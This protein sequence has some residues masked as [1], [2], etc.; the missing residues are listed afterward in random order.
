[1]IGNELTVINHLEKEC[2]AKTAFL[3]AAEYGIIRTVRTYL[4]DSP[5]IIHTVS[6]QRST[7]LHLAA[8]P[9]A[10]ALPNQ[11]LVE[12]LLEAGADVLARDYLGRTPLHYAIQMPSHLGVILRSIGSKTWPNSSDLILD[13]ALQAI[14]T[15][16]KDHIQSADNWNKTSFLHA[17]QSN[18]WPL[19]KAFV[20]GGFNADDLFD[21]HKLFGKNNSYPP[22][23]ALQIAILEGAKWS[24]DAS[25]RMVR[26]LLDAGVDP[27]MKGGHGETALHHAVWIGSTIIA[28]VL[29]TAGAD[30]NMPNNRG[31]API[32]WVTKLPVLDLLL[33]WGVDVNIQ[34]NR[35]MTALHLTLSSLYPQALL[36]PSLLKAK[37]NV[38][39][40][41]SAGDTPFDIA[42][43]LNY[44]EIDRML[45]D[46]LLSQ[47]FQSFNDNVGVSLRMRIKSALTIS[48]VPGLCNTLLNAVDELYYLLD[49]LQNAG[50]AL[51]FDI[52]SEDMSLADPSDLPCFTG[53]AW[54]VS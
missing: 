7:A 17:L 49:K 54:L 28:E 23:T 16:L 27:N 40:R 53:I 36:A 35:G 41:N 33:R 12:I 39:I 29:L 50:L 13:D 3:F 32:H 38:F 30:L 9:P 52:L 22:L 46:Y 37:A 42:A 26:V 19:V 18:N 31:Q 15:E 24:S 10:R 45:A 14:Q 20:F 25:M 44:R 43:R 21:R 11:K 1:M 51:G 48:K 4:N 2:S 34:D 8:L 47:P 5:R 6:R